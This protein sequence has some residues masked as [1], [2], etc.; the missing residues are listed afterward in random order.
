[1]EPTK[2]AKNE[3]D[4]RTSYRRRKRAEMHAEAEAESVQHAE[5]ESHQLVVTGKPEVIED[6]ASLV[7][8]AAVIRESGSF[9]YD[10]EF[11]GEETFLPRICLVQV[12]CE[13]RLALID[14]LKVDDLAPIFELVA[15]PEVETLVHDGAQDLEPARRA[16][17]V[18]PQGI[19]DTQVCAGF[20]DMPWPS[21][22]AKAVE[23]FAGH[24]LT[25]GH[26]FTDWDARPLT[27]RQVRYAAD[28]VRF[29]PLVWDRMRTQLESD[30]RLGWAM[31]ECEESRR[32]H[33]GGFDPEKH[34]RKIVRGSRLKPKA[35][36]VLR[37]IVELRHELAREQDL[38]HRVA[39]SDEAVADISKI[40]PV[41]REGLQRCR[42]IGRRNV[43][44]HADRILAAV[45]RGVD[46]P[47]RPLE[48]QKSRDENAEERM[49]IDAI[50]SALSLRCLADGIAPNLI[51]SRANLSRWYLDRADGKSTDPLFASDTWRYDAAGAWLEAF[52]AGRA[53][54]ELGW[55]DGRLHRAVDGV[56]SIEG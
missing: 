24:T 51:T 40:Q 46:G 18:E 52:L 20:L 19:V 56:G 39:M 5:I 23:R 25:K 45:K 41:D 36:T 11:I 12:A 6:Q 47:P 37:E 9:A 15:D 49:R 22:L 44:D 4:G 26:T 28:D 17:G 48:N 50:W 32:R 3:S 14:P 27:D 13:G 10:T 42:H 53:G 30:D 33:V 55:S 21:S 16:L 38:P 2:M 34:M 35:T 7:E 31:R 54:L 29:L 8:V 1:M 43:E